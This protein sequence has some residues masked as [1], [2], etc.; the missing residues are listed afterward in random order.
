MHTRQSAAEWGDGPSMTAV[1]AE[2]SRP[3]E[4]TNAEG[5]R[6]DLPPP[7]D[8]ENHKITSVL[9]GRGG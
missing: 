9:P 4:K 1:K 6:E 8:K 3:L 2:L 7:E 5:K